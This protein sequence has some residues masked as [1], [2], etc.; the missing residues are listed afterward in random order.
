M[1]GMG[2]FQYRI[3]LAAGLCFASD[4]MEV[5]LLSFLAVVLKYQWQLSDDQTASIVSS[6]FLGALLGTLVLGPLG[7]RI[8]RKPVFLFTAAII[9]VFGFATAAANAY[10]ELVLF[11]FLV[12]FGVGGLTVPFDT[13]SEFVPTSHRGTNLLAINYFWTIG[14]L[15][16][17][18]FAYYTLGNGDCQAENGSSEWR[19]F[20]LVC[21]VPCLLSTLVGIVFVP[22]S[23]RWLLT[24]GRHDEALQVLR[25]AALTN[26]K[27]PLTVFP[28]GTRLIDDCDD[29]HSNCLDLLSP[30][31]RRT[32]LFLWAAWAGLAFV[33]YGTIQAV[34]IAFADPAN[35]AEDREGCTSAYSFDY[36]AILTSAS[37]E[38]VGLTLV[39]LIVDKIGRIP[40]QVICYVLGGFAV[41]AM[42]ILAW[43]NVSKAGM[44]TTAFAARLL[45]MGSTCTTW[46]MT[47]ELFT[48]DVRTTGHAAS[49]AVAR[50]AGAVS[51]FLVAE[52][53]PFVVIG[54]FL[55]AVS[56]GTAYACYN[57]PETAGKSM[58]AIHKHPT[59]RDTDGGHGLSSGNDVAPV[60]AS[61]GVVT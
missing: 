17:P 28:D 27:N 55:L 43:L 31:W 13:L 51:P 50:L 35:G 8:G 32:S 41:F 61:Y 49:N 25:S 59:A 57:L 33:Y 56:L 36:G 7:D 34:T 12:G 16:V 10:P 6:S 11:R 4:S 3:L 44:V 53:T 30:T 42:S 26:L 37:S 24:Q 20:V 48:T 46:V 15:L 52:S 58:G 19:M 45:F 5:L 18:V 39:L 29:E 14:T 47:A 22:E 40:T 1:L 54:S 60:I 38:V 2:R 23:P 9:A 21:A